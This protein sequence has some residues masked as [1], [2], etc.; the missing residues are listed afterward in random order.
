MS[1]LERVSWVIAHALE[2]L[3][4]EVGEFWRSV[5]RWES[6][7]QEQVEQG[8]VVADMV[9]LF[10]HGECFLR[11]WEMGALEKSEVEM[12]IK[13]IGSWKVAGKEKGKERER[14]LEENLEVEGKD[15]EMTLQ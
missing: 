1:G 10:G 11:M 4:V 6:L 8:A 7:Q 15:V 13:K 5:M 3:V 14:V 12:S 9:E 2:D